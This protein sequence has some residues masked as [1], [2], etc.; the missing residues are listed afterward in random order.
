MLKIFPK[1]T[2]TNQGEY[3]LSDH[4]SQRGAGGTGHCHHVRLHPAPCPAPACLPRP[5]LSVCVW[6]MNSSEV[7]E[8]ASGHVP[9]SIPACTELAQEKPCLGGKMCLKYFLS[10]PK[11]GPGLSTCQEAVC[12][13]PAAHRSCLRLLPL[14]GSLAGFILS[15]N[16]PKAPRAIFESTSPRGSQL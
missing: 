1:S 13:S 6:R 9:P 11:R 5:G 8:P 4:T 10:S 16:L 2:S 15:Q 7:S 12:H 14:P 3:P